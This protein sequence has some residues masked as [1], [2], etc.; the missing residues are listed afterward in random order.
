MCMQDFRVG[1][2]IKSI[3]QFKNMI[4][5]DTMTIPANKI[6]VG[7]SIGVWSNASAVGTVVTVLIDGVFFT[8]LGL[9]NP[10]LYLSIKDYGDL[11]QLP[12]S[13][14]NGTTPGTQ[15]HFNEYI[16]DEAML[17]APLSEFER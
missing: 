12:M 5:A 2:Y 16:L 11:V 6:R 13:I 10:H 1:R 17:T 15:A 4:A 7:V 9:N 3:R 14:L 8:Q